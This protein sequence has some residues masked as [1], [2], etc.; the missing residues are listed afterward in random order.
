MHKAWNGRENEVMERLV[1][2]KEMID[3]HDRARKQCIKNYRVALGTYEVT[4]L[5]VEKYKV[6]KKFKKKLNRLNRIE[7]K[8]KV[9]L[10]RRGAIQK[11]MSLA[12][13][14]LPED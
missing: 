14:K 13:I 4:H 11:P 5:E 3:L 2:L 8:P 9:V 1:Y 6:T 10:G 12:N 7:R